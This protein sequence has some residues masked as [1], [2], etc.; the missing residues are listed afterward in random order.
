L[1][2]LTGDRSVALELRCAAIEILGQAG[3]TDALP[4]LTSLEIRLAGCT[5]GQ[6]SLGFAPPEPPDDAALLPVLRETLGR[7]REAS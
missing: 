1:A 3:F 6:L 5:A 2:R 4:L 7:L